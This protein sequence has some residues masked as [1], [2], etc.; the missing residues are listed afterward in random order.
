MLSFASPILMTMV[1]FQAS[2]KY[3]FLIILKS[4]SECL[5]SPYL[6]LGQQ[7]FYLSFLLYTRRLPF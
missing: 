2:Q 6:E 1:D 3:H 5:P 7:F 4:K